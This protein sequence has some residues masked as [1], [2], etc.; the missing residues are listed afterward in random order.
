MVLKR[1]ICYE[2]KRIYGYFN[3]AF[4]YMN[5]DTISKEKRPLRY[6]IVTADKFPPIRV[7]VSVLFGYE[8]IKRGHNIDWL[9]QSEKYAEA[10]Q[11]VN[12]NGSRVFVGAS[13]E[14]VSI[15]SRIKKNILSLSLDSKMF[16]LAS[17]GKYDFIQVKDKFMSAILA[18]IAS[19]RNNCKLFY[20]LSYPFP[21]AS[22]YEAKVGIARYPMLYLIRGYIFKFLLYK[23]IAPCADHLFVQ[24]EQMKRDL[25][26]NGVSIE[27]LTTVP[28]GV[29]LDYFQHLI[30]KDIKYKSNEKNV[31]Y[32]GTLIATRKL[33]FIIQAFSRVLQ[34]TPNAKLYMVGPEE[35]PNDMAILESEARRLGIENNIVFTGGLS[36]SE[37]LAYVNIADVC[38]SPFYPTPILNSTS[39]TKLIEYMMMKKPVVVNDHPEQSL[40][41]SE[42]EAGICVP[43]RRDAFAQ[44]IIKILSDDTLA[45]IMG[46]KGYEYVKRYRTYEYLSQQVESCYLKL[47]RDC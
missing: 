41:V 14:G 44:A 11:E 37:A 31:V 43:Y 36:R 13:N 40:V 38:V 17:D 45:K 4:I 25:E 32:M 33:D 6:L 27:K 18:I 3:K 22:I 24:S 47:C 39:P 15:F 2:V 8:M 30:L 42:S 9:M 23:I 12:W 34:I 19:R 5:N 7:D 21:E 26:N 10:T 29:S 16:Q 1:T 28:M 20:W 46:E 35:R